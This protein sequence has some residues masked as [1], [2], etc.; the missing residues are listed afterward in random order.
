MRDFLEERFR[1]HMHF[2]FTHLSAES[3]GALGAWLAANPPASNSTQAREAFLAAF[4]EATKED[5][6]AYE[7]GEN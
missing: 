2:A 3:I 4:W 1:V 7:T 6:A 5:G